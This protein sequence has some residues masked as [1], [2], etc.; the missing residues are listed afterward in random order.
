[1][2]QSYRIAHA[3]DRV[4]RRIDAQMHGR[5]REVDTARI[6]QLGGLALLHLDEMQPCSIH[7]LCDRMGRDN[8]QMTRVIR[9]LET[10]GVVARSGDPSDG[11]VS[12]LHLT[13][14]GKS[15]IEEM[16]TQ[17]SEVVNEAT[18]TLTGCEREVLLRLLEKL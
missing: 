17:L 3:L 4:V 14:M 11:R 13:P 9:G 5:M 8:S 2:S 1:M 7:A 10:K 6:G 18:S 12:L 15:F 16:K